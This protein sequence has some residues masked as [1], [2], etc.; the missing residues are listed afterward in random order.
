MKKFLL[1]MLVAIM[2]YFAAMLAIGGQL[3]HPQASVDELTAFAV[4][5]VWDGVAV[6][7]ASVTRSKTSS[8]AS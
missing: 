3:G 4:E 2:I 5:R 8:R 6:P 7:P 1:F